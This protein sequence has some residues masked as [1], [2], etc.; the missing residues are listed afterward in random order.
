MDHGGGRPNRSDANHDRGRYGSRG[1]DG[2]SGWSRPGVGRLAIRLAAN[3]LPPAAANRQPP[4]ASRQPPER[5]RA[6]T[7]RSGGERCPSG[8]GLPPTPPTRQPPECVRVPTP[9]SGG[10]RSAVSG[11]PM[12]RGQPIVRGEPIARRE[13][14][15]RSQPLCSLH[16][17]SALESGNDSTE[18]A[19]AGDV[20]R[21]RGT[22]VFGGSTAIVAGAPPD[23]TGSA[24]VV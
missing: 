9:R 16:C 15:A 22:S 3:R 23:E 21:S 19:V 2:E 17:R 5:V 10:E 18:A 24:I 4:T 20:P 6:P 11:Q 12:A 1:S 8:H 13:P 7:P 14:L